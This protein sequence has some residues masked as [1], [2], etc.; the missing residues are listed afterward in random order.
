MKIFPNIDVYQ[1]ENDEPLFILLL[2]LL[3]SVYEKGHYFSMKN[4]KSIKKTA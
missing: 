1:K 2:L 3:Y 4:N